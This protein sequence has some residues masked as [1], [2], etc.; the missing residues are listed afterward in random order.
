M[1]NKTFKL[2][3]YFLYTSKTEEDCVVVRSM[4]IGVVTPIALDV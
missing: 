2:L 1:T 3:K 4:E